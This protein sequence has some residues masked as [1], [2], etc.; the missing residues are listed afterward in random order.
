MQMGSNHPLQRGWNEKKVVTVFTT[1][2]LLFC[3]LAYLGVYN[4]FNI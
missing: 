1:V 2:S 3:V 4:R